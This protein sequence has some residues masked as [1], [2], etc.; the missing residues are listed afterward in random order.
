MNSLN[1]DNRSKPYFSKNLS[2]FSTDIILNLLKCLKNILI[3]SIQ[4][5][6]LFFFHG[7]VPN[8]KN[9]YSIDKLLKNVNV[10]PVGT[11]KYPTTSL[12]SDTKK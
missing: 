3:N 6:F 4:G 8:I 9:Y 2:T 1:I 5:S 10:L 11:G 7:Y 12:Y